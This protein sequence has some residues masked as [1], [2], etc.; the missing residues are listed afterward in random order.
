MGVLFVGASILTAQALLS[1]TA[2]KVERVIDGDTFETTEKQLIRINGIDAPELEM[3]GGED[4]KATLGKLLND[5]PLQLKVLRRDQYFRLVSD[6]Y[7]DGKSVAT[8]MLTAGQ[9]VRRVTNDEQD[10]AEMDNAQQ[11]A[12]EEKIGIFGPGCTQGTNPKDKKCNI[13][14]NMRSGYK[15]RFYRYPGCGQYETTLVQLHLGDRWFC[16]E[17][18]AKAAGFVRGADCNL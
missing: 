1:R 5:K 9:A 13:K 2:Y 12:K 4:A 10:K 6:V 8:L 7:V 11:I 16:S 3:C 14:G 18:E 15:D 17:K